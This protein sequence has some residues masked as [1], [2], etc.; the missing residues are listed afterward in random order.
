MLLCGVFG[1]ALPTRC[2]LLQYFLALGCTLLVV[3]RRSS[4]PWVLHAALWCLW[5][6]LAHALSSAAC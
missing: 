6:G 2:P 3:A 5:H 4:G 1:T